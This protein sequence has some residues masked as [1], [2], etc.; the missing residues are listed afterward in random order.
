MFC[1]FF[2][3]SSSLE[4]DEQGEGPGDWPGDLLI[5]SLTG[6]K[7][8]TNV[9]FGS[10]I[11]KNASTNEMDLGQWSILKL[12]FTGVGPAFSS[13]R[14][15]STVVGCISTVV[16]GIAKFADVPIIFGCFSSYLIYTMLVDLMSN[17]SSILGAVNSF[18]GFV[19]VI[20]N[21][22]TLVDLAC[23]GNPRQSSV[24]SQ[25]NMGLTQNLRFPMERM[26]L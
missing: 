12:C 11:G 3:L 15:I 23:K 20:T 13:D 1:V 18:C 22:L 2:N 6:T 21:K 16:G 10:D 7:G 25:K 8:F 19:V 9:F 14:Y 24:I 5:R 4:Q 17:L 26:K